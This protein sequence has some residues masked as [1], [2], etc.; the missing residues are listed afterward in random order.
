MPTPLTF[1]TAP[2]SLQSVL[3]AATRMSPSPYTAVPP[4]FAEQ[5]PRAISYAESRICSEIPLLAN[6]HTDSTLNV[7]A[8]ARLVN[9]ANLST[10][11]IVVERIA[12]ITPGGGTLPASGTRNQYIKTTLDFIDVFWP[13]EATTLSP[14]LAEQTGRYWAYVTIASGDPVTYSEIA[15][16]PTPDLAYKIEVTGLVQPEP[17]SS[18]NQTTYL[19]TFY[20]DLLTAGCMVYLEGA[21]KRNF[22][23]QSDDPRQAV[24]WEGQFEKLKAVCQF[25]EA[26]RRGLAPDTPRPSAPVAS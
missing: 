13:T 9:L 18:S 7:S 25:E 11:M 5:Y 22:G 20:G 16:A 1:N 26:R 23:S 17:L 24:S 3:L 8:G 21:L 19:S 6:R 12:L 2:N 4:D 10:P 15:L 14:I